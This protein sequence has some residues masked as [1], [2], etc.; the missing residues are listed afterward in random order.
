MRRNEQQHDVERL[1]TY[2]DDLVTG[3]AADSRAGE[4]PALA[5]TIQG[6]HRL[7]AVPDVDPVFADRLGARLDHLAT[8]PRRR[9]MGSIRP[10]RIGMPLLPG[11][12]S[13]AMLVIATLLV[14]GGL[15]ASSIPNNLGQDAEPQRLA[16]PDTTPSTPAPGVSGDEGDDTFAGPGPIGFP[17]IAWQVPVGTEFITAA[18]A[19]G[20]S[21]I[22][23]GVLS[24][25]DRWFLRS[26]SLITGATNWTVEGEASD[27]D[28]VI[29]EITRGRILIRTALKV[30][31]FDAASGDLVWEYEDNP[32]GKM[33]LAALAADNG[34]VATS[35][36][37]GILTVLDATNGTI[38]W[39]YL[40]G[41]DQLLQE[42][43][44]GQG[45]LVL[46]TADGKSTALNMGTG[47]VL[48]TFAGTDVRYVSDTLEG[49]RVFLSSVQTNPSPY[50]MQGWVLVLDAASGQPFGDRIPVRSGS[51]FA[52][53]GDTLVVSGSGVVDAIDIRSGATRWTRDGV[54][55]RTSPTI[56]GKQT[57][58]WSRGDGTIRAFDLVDGSGTWGAYLGFANVAAV[59]DGYLI[60]ITPNELIA[61]TG[62][63]HLAWDGSTPD[64]SGL[65]QCTLP[66]SVP[67]A[68]V[69]GEP[70]HVLEAETQD[71]RFVTQFATSPDD[72]QDVLMRWLTILPD[73]VP[74]G[75]RPPATDIFG[76]R[77]ILR[78][79]NACEMRP[80]A[81]PQ[82]GKFFTDDFYRRGNVRFEDGA[83][84]FIWNLGPDNDQIAAI[85]PILLGDGRI[86]ATFDTAEAWDVV[87]VLVQQDG[88]WLIDE[89]L[90]IEP[91]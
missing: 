56:V 33:Y 12:A 54:G 5:S 2:W 91:R 69:T 72:R 48:W 45:I 85:E 78:M 43:V 66:Q 35:T 65:A 52:V 14:I 36:G 44:I 82:M 68:E 80:E 60:A 86:A 21:I 30:M 10:P 83:Y 90:A 19:S 81:A 27:N 1:D 88:H 37:T 20:D 24:T 59:V 87:I 47:Q 63:E 64:F 11:W 22:L 38:I 46:T 89:V 32:T 26:V 8:H 9:A 58:I 42:P 15:F 74:T 75:S 16:A 31:A 28:Y 50:T 6:I 76:V 7:D 25:G 17:E 41:P 40:L 3:H 29:P 79:M 73:D 57:F 23:S 84:Q 62:N 71:A 34:R 77:D 49:G 55:I 70:A 53:Q 61:I 4:Y 39:E 67:A 18:K 13:Q 51:S